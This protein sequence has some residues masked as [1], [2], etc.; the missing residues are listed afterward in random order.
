MGQIPRAAVT[1]DFKQ[2]FI[3]L[4]FK[5]LEAQ[6]KMSAG[7]HAGLGLGET[8]PPGLEDGNVT[9]RSKGQESLGAPSFYRKHTPI[10][11]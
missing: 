6:I 5:G 3:L 9:T 11:F 1:D 2:Q 4:L 8:L 7:S 10:P